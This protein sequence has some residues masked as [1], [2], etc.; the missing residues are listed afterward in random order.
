MKLFNSWV[1]HYDL[2]GNGKRWIE[3]RDN[4]IRGVLRN[5]RFRVRLT[6]SFGHKTSIIGKETRFGPIRILCGTAY[7]YVHKPAGMTYTGFSFKGPKKEYMILPTG[8]HKFL[9]VTLERS[10]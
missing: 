5:G 3:G 8:W 6:N 10:E 2:F 9:F 7:G 4:Q 1:K